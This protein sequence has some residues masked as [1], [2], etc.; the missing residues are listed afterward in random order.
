MAAFACGC[1]FGFGGFAIMILGIILTSTSVRTCDQIIRTNGTVVSSSVVTVANPQ[2]NAV[3]YYSDIIFEYPSAGDN[4]TFTMCEFMSTQSD[5][6]TALRVTTNHSVGSNCSIYITNNRCYVSN[7]SDCSD[8]QKTVG[9]ILILV[10]GSMITYLILAAFG[11][12]G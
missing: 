11:F 1:L 6:A 4:A 2:S 8:N 3:S 7:T 12:C 9:D 5:Y 10:G